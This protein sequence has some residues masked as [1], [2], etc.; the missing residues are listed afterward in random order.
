MS[1]KS[2][3][4]NA[5]EKNR[6]KPVS[7]QQLADEL[8]VSRA[9]VW[10]AIQSLLQEGYSISAT[11]CKGYMLDENSDI[12]SE[13]GL[14]TCLRSRGVNTPLV[15]FSETDST[16]IQAK[17]IALEGGKHG[18]A[19]VANK[20]T[21][22]R[23]RLRRSFYSPADTGIYLSVLLSPG[24]AVPE[25][26]MITVYA[27][28]AA[29]RAIEKVCGVSVGIKWVNDLYLN[30]KKICGILTEATLSM[31]G[32]GIDNIIIGIGINCTGSEDDLPD[33]IRGK[34]GFIGKGGYTRNELAA[35][36]IAQI[37][38]YGD[39]VFPDDVIEEY[40]NRSILTGRKVNYTKG[41][42]VSTGSVLGI[43]D[44]G[45]LIVRSDSGDTDELF[46]GEVSI[47]QF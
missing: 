9:A 41:G 35:E 38:R 12:L 22:G 14:L 5:L 6:C 43:S 27:A 33:D 4:I 47:T 7:G 17:R 25:P 11:R 10:K 18:T 29:A 20:Q 31:E 3:I 24:G 37:I 34:A 2:D 36:V 39:C 30:E 13:A 45:C 8:G 21:A 23:G 46:S 16:N 19:V 26:Q 44:S 28:V 32:G 40:R 42:A 15:F 1:I